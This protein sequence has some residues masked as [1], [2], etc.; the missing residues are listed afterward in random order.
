MDNDDLKA[1]KA[2]WSTPFQQTPRPK[3][4]LESLHRALA[5]KRTWFPPLRPNSESSADMMMTEEK[6]AE[7]PSAHVA[8]YQ[9]DFPL[10]EYK[11]LYL[12]CDNIIDTQKLLTDYSQIAKQCG[13]NFKI[14]ERSLDFGTPK[15][16]FKD[17][18]PA[19]ISE[20]EE[21]IK[22]FFDNAD[23][24]SSEP[25]D[26]TGGERLY[27][28]QDTRSDTYIQV[29][30]LRVQK[31]AVGTGC[32]LVLMV[33][34]IPDIMKERRFKSAKITCKISR[35]KGLPVPKIKN[36]QP[37]VGYADKDGPEV[38]N[39]EHAELAIGVPLVKGTVG[40]SHSNTMKRIRALGLCGLDVPTADCAKVLYNIRE[41]QSTGHGI[42]R[43]LP[44]FIALDSLEA[45]SLEVEV[46]ASVIGGI[47]FGNH[48]VSSQFKIDP[49][50][51]KEPNAGSDAMNLAA[52]ESKL[53]FLCFQILQHA[54]KDLKQDYPGIRIFEEL[55]SRMIIPLPDVGDEGRLI[56]GNLAEKEG[57]KSG[58]AKGCLH[59]V[60]DAAE[61]HRLAFAAV[62]C[63]PKE[64]TVFIV[65][66]SLQLGILEHPVRKRGVRYYVL[67]W[68][69]IFE[70]LPEGSPL[71]GPHWR[72]R[73][74]LTYDDE[75]DWR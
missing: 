50:K 39:E 66:P 74:F 13:A 4:G 24:D 22:N 68:H 46:H 23:F 29:H 70:A 59:F 62:A 56:F 34:F 65:P 11:T 32:L 2:H 40:G 67:I 36:Y 44:M 49:A 35:D 12:G 48:T 58:I 28:A 27:V 15:A 3:E 45:F 19:I 26:P 52:V 51:W 9:K 55:A 8:S 20:R 43:N 7:N 75:D 38:K 31:K 1:H 5:A 6:F 17:G 47:P 60:D 57:E 25:E 64:S 63:N 10:A 21:Q 42:F 14:S 72:G 61:Q 54:R 16:P 73:S 18:K 69:R 53:K 71:Q 30:L 41:N 37:R 33:E